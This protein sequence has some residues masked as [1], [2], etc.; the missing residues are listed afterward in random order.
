MLGA[1][2]ATTIRGSMNGIAAKHGCSSTAQFKQ[3]PCRGTKHELHTWGPAQHCSNINWLAPLRLLILVRV[4]N[5][6]QS[7]FVDSLL[8]KMFRTCTHPQEYCRYPNIMQ[9]ACLLCWESQS[10]R[11]LDAM[12]AT[13]VHGSMNGSAAKHVCSSTAEFN[14]KPC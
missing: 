2:M 3:K 8:C 13:T 6:F 1:M 11:M 14:E 5:A 10:R 7:V 12:M 4:P 9:T